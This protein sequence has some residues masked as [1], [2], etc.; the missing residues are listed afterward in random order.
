MTNDE[1][2]MLATCS[3]RGEVEEME[4]IITQA[5]RK[6]EF[7]DYALKSTVAELIRNQHYSI[8]DQFIIQ[9]IIPTDLYDCDRFD[10]TVI[11]TL[12]NPMM[13]ADD[14]LESY[15]TWF[16]S[17]LKQ[18]E[19]IDEQVAGVTLLEYALKENAPIGLLKTI[20]T[21][22]ADIHRIDQY[23]QTLLFKACNL[24]MQVAERKSSIV[25]WLLSEGIDPHI[26]NVEQKTALHMA[27]DT[28]NTEFITSLMDAGADA[29]FLD[30]HGES[31]FYYAAVRQSNPDLLL[32]MLNYSQPD[33]HS[34]NKQ[35]ENL[36]N[37]F[38][39]MMHIENDRHLHVLSLL[40]SNGADLTEP[41]L[42][43]QK[44][45][46]GIDWLVEKSVITLEEVMEKDF[47][48]VNYRDDQGN[49]LLHKVCQVNINYDESKARDLY[50]K[51]KYLVDKGVDPRIEN[52]S[53]KKAVDYAMEDNLK[54]KTVEWLLKY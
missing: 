8:L 31:A 3:G 48:D 22:G 13:L 28:S 39:R 44:A 45:K 33:F 37:A 7:Q 30:W 35:G 27:V 23:G 43:Y 24:R 19:D 2:R 14:L 17:Y 4:K 21:A 15:Q 25:D 18:V 16:G 54:I 20:V 38:L 50:K 26:A 12:I 40:L 52:S 29:N 11:S 10:H 6:I 47:I 51:V 1:L 5:T 49:T 9:G 32:N 42:W 36:L 41:S 34:V 46:T 53:D